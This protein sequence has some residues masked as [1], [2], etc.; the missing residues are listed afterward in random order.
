MLYYIYIQ[1]KFG[2]DNNWHGVHPNKLRAS[3]EC[4]LKYVFASEDLELLL[5]INHELPVSLLQ[6]LSEVV[7]HSINGLP[8]YLDRD[9]AQF[10]HAVTFHFKPDFD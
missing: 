4:D 10:Q 3:I 8:A 9:R 5:Q 6:V 7:L 1:R 2:I